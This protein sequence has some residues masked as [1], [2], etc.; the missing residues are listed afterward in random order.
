MF[1]ENWISGVAE[2]LPLI[3]LLGIIIVSILI[4]AQGAEWVV[5]EAVSLSAKLGIPQVVVGA[6]IVSLGTTLPEAAVSVLAAIQGNPE[7]ALGN[8]VGSIIADTGLIL[9]I[10]TLMAPLPINRKIVN[11]Q[12]WIQVA[13]GLLLIAFCIPFGNIGSVFSE[14]GRLQQW[15]GF[16]L[17]GLLVVYLLYSVFSTRQTSKAEKLT[18]AD[19]LPHAKSSWLSLL[20]LI[21]G[22][23]LILIAAQ[24]LIP[25]VETSAIRIG[26]PESIVAA[27]LVALGTSLP[28]LVTAIT[29]VRKGHGEIALG[30]VI[31]ADILNVLFVAGLSAAVTPVGLEAGGHFFAILFPVMLGLFFIFRMGIWL[32]GEFLPRWAG[33]L[34]LL[35]YIAV[36]IGGYFGG[37]SAK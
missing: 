15:H 11:K 28:E 6:T 21:A 24:I 12:G 26:V 18:D 36:I 5:E 9:G 4:L 25:T 31:G 13:S 33:L 17:V 37:Y 19:T 35:G 8:A 10:A 14:G 27:T 7:I 23:F 3:A 34:L 16:V 20:K 2:G 1:I 30:N 29:S 32:G 22:I